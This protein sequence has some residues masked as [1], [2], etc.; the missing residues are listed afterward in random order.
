MSLQ[1]AGL[2]DI[3]FGPGL[4]KNF[5]V[6]Y[7][8]SL[9]TSLP[10]AQ[11]AVV[12][13][14]LIANCNFLLGAV[15]SAFTTV[16]AWFNT[17]SNKF[18]T[19]NRQQVYLNQPDNT[20]ASNTGYGNPILVDSQSQNNNVSI[21]GPE[22]AALWMAEFSEVLMGIAGN[23]N[24]GD[25]SGEG[26]SQYSNI[27]TAQTGHYDY[28][29]SFVQS[30]LNGGQAWSSNN[31]QFVA[32][33]NSARSDWVTT[34]FT[35]T[36]TS[37]GDN[38]HGD[39]DTVSFGCALCFIYY[40]NVQ[41]SF[42]IN[43][44][45][46]AYKNNLATAYQTLTGDSGSPFSFFL[47]LVQ[48]VFPA[49][50]TATIPGPV[51]DN[52]FPIAMVSFWDQ[53]NTFG[54]D[55]AKD[56]INTQGGL[57]SGAFWVEVQGFSKQSFNSLG[58]QVGNFTGSFAGLQGVKITPNPKGAQFESGVNDQTPQR[59][60]IPFDITL[61]SLFVSTSSNNF[62]SSGSNSFDLS[63]TLTSNGTQVSGSSA[64]TEFE[65]LAGADPYF[66][67]IDVNIGNE[68]YLS[69][70]LRVFTGTPG[71]NPFPFPN[72][73]KFDTDSPAGAYTYIQKLL[74]YLNSTPSFNNR[75][76]TDPFSLLPNQAGEDQTDS[77]VT[78]FTIDI[79]TNFPP[80]INLYN[81]Y[82]FAIARVRLQGSPGPTDEADNV[83]VFFRLWVTQTID[84]D[85][86]PTSTYP[87]NPDP[88]G[89]PGSPKVGA[90][91][92]TIPMFAT[93]D[94]SSNT[95]YS[96]G[97]PNIQKL[98][99][100]TGQDTFYYYYGCFLNLYDPN[101][102][103]DGKQ[104]QKYLVGTHHCLVAQI[105]YDSA[106]IP[107]GS[108]PLSWD[109]LAQRNL[110]IT[111][112]DNP[113]PASTHRIPQTFDCRP[114]G[115]IAVPSTGDPVFPDE[116]MIDWGNVPEGSIASLYWPQVHASDVIDLANQFYSSNP[117]SASD[118]HT[119]RIVVTRG[120]SYVPIPPGAGQN[121]AGL[122]T[123]DLPKTVIAG[124]QFN[125]QVRRIATK[126]Y[127]PPPPP[128]QIQSPRR[129]HS[130]AATV[131]HPASLP[132]RKGKR[133]GK[134]LPKP[135]APPTPPPTEPPGPVTISWRYVTGSFAVQ[136][137]VTT[138]DKML[139][140][141]EITLAIMKWRLE[142]MAP[143]NR[144][145]PV[146][147]RYIH[148]LSGCVDGLGGNSSAVPP[149]L[150]WVPPH[151]TGTGGKGNE[152]QVFTGKICEVLF[153]CHGDFE[154]FVL[155]DCCQEHRFECRV[156]NIG[157]LVLRACREQLLVSVYVDRNCG[158]RVARLV[159]R[160]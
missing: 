96:T 24:A 74:T 97:G 119:I 89:L 99:I 44:I 67:N 152:E 88:A 135:P 64:T 31:K 4:T 59:I 146:L 120:V 139:P 1:S 71:K 108:S 65:L 114:S 15:E 39:G 113:G 144:W 158:H 133:N 80:T 148:Y 98:E 107:N 55:E 92:N 58:I 147:E 94:F 136:V 109:Q 76:G 12:K 77:S 56:I 26:L 117:L 29:G 27:T 13:A 72:G 42:S 149:S 46:A 25:S 54:L 134:S 53:K 124:Q 51:S 129:T 104:V 127:Q 156:R 115:P 106:P 79:G 150:T 85:Y 6:Q 37:L 103:I 140:Q 70:D 7:E 121:F 105:A 81:N 160:Q 86:D 95:D 61:S 8:S 141:E 91:D 75:F 28:Y 48:S 137:P 57:V 93:G 101:N 126:T 154:G 45:I 33:P 102:I 128:P 20:G 21:A 5:Q 60:Q 11:Q 38:I 145:H 32:S 23:W 68:A 63:V 131:R 112:S 18:G 155:C 125:I 83:R 111:S 159:V 10:A 19:S 138:A 123:V 87:S 110:Q 118:M 100:P 49:S 50:Q 157:E 34:T 132:L 78:P 153:D 43:Q 73:P 52:P 35:G 116:L 82:N 36:T 9:Y 69:N 14:N 62:P 30:W 17:P 40:L 3:G 47:T 90:G 66:S 122:F 151:L 16:T 22:E 41:L 143:S 84:T 130:M 142:E 2:T